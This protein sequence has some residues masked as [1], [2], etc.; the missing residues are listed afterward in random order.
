MINHQVIQRKSL[1][2]LLHLLDV[3]LA[4]S[5]RLKGFPTVGDGYTGPHMPAN[6]V[7]V[8]L[9]SPTLIYSSFKPLL[10]PHGVAKAR[11][12]AVGALLGAP[13]VLEGGDTGSI[14][15]VNR[16]IRNRNSSIRNVS[17]AIRDVSRPIRNVSRPIRDMNRPIRNVNSSIRDVNR[18]IINY[19]IFAF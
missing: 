15:E 2:S 3:D 4:E 17:R 19:M 10:L 6:P 18:P 5:T 12:P 8:L 9:T 14:G 1:F 11:A 13:G 7:A 16:P